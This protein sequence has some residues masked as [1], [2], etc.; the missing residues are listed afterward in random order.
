MKRPLNPGGE[1]RTAAAAQTGGLDHIGHFLWFHG[2]DGFFESRE[3]AIFLVDIQ[4]ADP[5]N[6]TVTQQQSSHYF[7]SRLFLSGA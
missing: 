4:V 7:T 2:R 5:G 1:T 6:I 3:T